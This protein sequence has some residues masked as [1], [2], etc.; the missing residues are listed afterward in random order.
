[1]TAEASKAEGTV[2]ELLSDQEKQRI[3]SE[4]WG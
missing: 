3:Y 2:L 1:M 4:Q